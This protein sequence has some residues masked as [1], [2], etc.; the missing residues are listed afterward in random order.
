MKKHFHLLS[1]D[2]KY[3]R[4]FLPDA[5]V[6]Y[7]EVVAITESI[8]EGLVERLIRKLTP[9]LPADAVIIVRGVGEVPH[10]YTNNF[11]DFTNI[12]LDEQ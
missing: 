3:S 6:P 7:S 10:T 11:K 9:D 2:V 4:T 5:Y 1:W 8:S 12:N